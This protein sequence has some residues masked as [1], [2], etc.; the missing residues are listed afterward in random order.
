MMVAPTFV[1]WKEEKD[2]IDC[3]VVVFI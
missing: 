3:G 1:G 2:G